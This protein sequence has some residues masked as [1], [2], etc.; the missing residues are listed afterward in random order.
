MDNQRLFLFLALTLVV[1]ML[2]QSW[3]QDY[4]PKPDPQL[5]LQTQ[6]GAEPAGEAEDTGIPQLSDIPAPPPQTETPAPA[7]A[8]TPATAQAKATSPAPAPGEEVTVTTDVLKLVFNTRGGDLRRVELLT[9]AE[10]LDKKDVPFRLLNDTL[11]D[12][13]VAQS[14]FLTRDQAPAPNHNALFHSELKDYQLGDGQDQLVIPFTWTHPSGIKVIKRYT[15]KRDSYLI[16]LDVEVSNGS[17][18]PWKGR[19]YRQL[20]RTKVKERNQSSMI[21]TY[22][23][24]VASSTYNKYEKVKF[25]EMADWKPKE[26]YVTGGWVAM[27]QHYFLSAWVAA[28]DQSNHFYTQA[29]GDE[30]F[31]IGM[32]GVEQELAPGASTVFKSGLFAG[33][34]EPKRLEQAAPHLELTV[35][36]GILTL[37]A[38]PLYWVLDWFH[39]LVGNWGWA[40]ILLTILIKLIFYKLSEASYK[41]MARMRKF[42]PKIQALRDRYGND[43]QRMSQAMME[44][45]K[46]EKINPLGGCLPILVQIPV[47]IALYW[48]LLESVELRQAEFILWIVDLSARDPYYVLPLIMGASMF[49]QQRL[50]PAPM[51]PIQQKVMMFLP[52]IFTLFFMVFPAGL[53]LYWVVNNILSISQ[54]WYITRKIAATSG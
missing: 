11:P 46:K 27:A 49:L 33:P 36:Y 16:D 4:G 51:D 12:L 13:Y 53:V 29:H 28:P 38:K 24:G 20:E 1:M 15:V 8:P 5:A 2:W 17:G 41:S 23:G 18:S 47:F 39:G 19:L 26:S 7:V 34:K 35:D 3:Q 14:G 6:P 22:M 9:Y 48:T 43:R 50:N 42:Q 54:Q 31:I 44:L 21:V 25:D 37:I 52:I 10:S 30:R 32:S 40:I 45:Y